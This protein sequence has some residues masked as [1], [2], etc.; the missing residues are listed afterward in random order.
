MLYLTN[1]T[2]DRSHRKTLWATLGS[3]ACLWL[4]ME[5]S[6]QLWD[7]RCCPQSQST[8]G[9]HSKLWMSS[10]G[11]AL[12]H[13]ERQHE[14]LEARSYHTILAITGVQG[15]AESQGSLHESQFAGMEELR[16][17]WDHSLRSLAR[18]V[19]QLPSRYGSTARSIH[20]AR[21]HQQRWQLRAEKLLVGYQDTTGNQ[22]KIL[23]GGLK[24]A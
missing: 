18:I 11:I 3:C 10:E 9:Q 14:Q 19:R 6:L 4:E 5:H 24:H 16:R 17:A 22:S 12:D 1:A 2:L 7:D 21:P 23:T 20:V 15:V 8:F 13:E